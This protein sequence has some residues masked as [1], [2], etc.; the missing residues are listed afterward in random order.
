MFR[1]IAVLLLSVFLTSAALANDILVIVN[2]GESTMSFVDAKEMKLLATVPT[3]SG[4]HEVVTS[5]DGKTAF[6][7]IYGTQQPGSML[8]IFDVAT[9]KELKRF[10]LMPL[11]RPHGMVVLGGKIYLSAEANNAVGR[12][13]IAAGKVDWLIG[14]GQSVSHM[15]VVSADQKKIYTPNIG[16]DTVTAIEFNNVPPAASKTTHIPVGKQPEAIDI[17]PDGKQVW[18]GLNGDAGIDVIDTATNKVI[19]RVKLGERPY[20]VR[21]TPDGKF[22][23]ATMPNTKELI[24]IDAATRKETKRIKLG[25]SPLG[26]IFTPDG[27]IAYVTASSEDVVLKIDME[28]G[29]VIAKAAVGKTPDGI[30]IG[31]L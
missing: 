23:M 16:S 6:V 27:K 20:R 14:T 21:F 28:T 3:A 25:S 19:D 29:A 5:A 26:L 18:A 12:Y 8:A 4:P 17:S 24:I 7:S 15:V 1:T 31:K 10:D 30:A 22:V 11:M 2:R 13:D 9:Q